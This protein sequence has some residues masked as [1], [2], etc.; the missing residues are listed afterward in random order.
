M[1]NEEKIMFNDN[2]QE[3]TFIERLSSYLKIVFYVLIL[4]IYKITKQD[5]SKLTEINEKLF[6]I[7][8]NLK[9]YKKATILFDNILNYKSLDNID[10]KILVPICQC[11]FNLNNYN[12]VIELYKIVLELSN[13]DRTKMV[14]I[15]TFLVYSYINKGEFDS[16][17]NYSNKLQQEYGDIPKS[18]PISLLALGY[19]CLL[20]KDYSLAFSYLY[21]AIEYRNQ[22]PFLIHSF[23]S[24]IA[25]IFEEMVKPEFKNLALDIRKLLE[26]K[27]ENVANLFNIALKNRTLGFMTNQSVFFDIS[28]E[29]LNMLVKGNFSQRDLIRNK[30]KPYEINH[31]FVELYC[32][33]NEIDKAIYYLNELLKLELN[34]I[35]L[36]TY[37][38]YQSFLYYKKKDYNK[39]I[40]IAK[41]SLKKYPNESCIYH[42]LSLNYYELNDL[43]QALISIKEAISLDPFSPEYYYHLGRILL[44]KEEKEEAQKYFFSAFKM[45]IMGNL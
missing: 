20:K 24:S 1:K 23:Y 26:N 39:S 3:L 6:K 15:L 17:I 21:K 10:K 37:S 33:K 41:E 36:K 42:Y 35:H 34:E 2:V 45:Q 18:Q 14:S 32:E 43:E 7:Y 40:N 11:Y 9:L 4:L 28:I 16:A 30:I 44:I 31:F 27:K 13:I 8:F 5:N 12:K 29:Y 25:L 19:I 22:Y 38:I